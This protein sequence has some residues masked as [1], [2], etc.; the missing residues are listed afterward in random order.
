MDEVKVVALEF[1]G[2]TGLPFPSLRN[3]T[4]RDMKG[5]EAWS[6]SNS[7]VVDTAFPCL[8]ELRIEC[9]PNLVSVSVK[10]LP[11]LRVLRISGCNH[12]VLGNL[13]HVSVTTLYI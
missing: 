5:W 1:L 13:V 4:F 10:A 6:T 9:C 7:G 11:S 12:E 2:T 3:L 8:K